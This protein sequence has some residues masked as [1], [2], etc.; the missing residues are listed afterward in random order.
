VV[1][2]IVHV[3]SFVFLPIWPTTN[4]LTNGPKRTQGFVVFTANNITA[5]LTD[6]NNT[7]FQLS[8]HWT[9]QSIV[10]SNWLVVGTSTSNNYSSSQD[11]THPDDQI[12]SRHY[13]SFLCSNLFQEQQKVT[14]IRGVSLS[15]YYNYIFCGWC[16]FWA[17]VNWSAAMQLKS[18]YGWISWS[19]FKFKRGP[20][21]RF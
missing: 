12:S 6:Y 15:F 4:S 3:S 11:F 5:H 20:W 19:N 13:K 7:P 8:N 14:N 9:D 10:T 16:S 17:R 2:F 21:R 18:T 1:F